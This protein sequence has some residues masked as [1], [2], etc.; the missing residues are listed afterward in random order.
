MGSGKSTIGSRLAQQ[1]GWRFV[2]LDEK[3][4]AASGIAIPQF[5]ERHGEG[6]FRQLEAE[7]LRAALGR[8]L[9]RQEPTIIALGGGTYAQLGAPEFLRNSGRSGPVARFAH[10][11]SAFALHDH[12]WPPA[13][14]R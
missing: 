3:I 10:R 2:D 9:E 8:S 5:F 11:S 14:P 6:A 4:E 7:Q 1:L 13:F 12:D